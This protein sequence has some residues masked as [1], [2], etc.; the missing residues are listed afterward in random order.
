M[1]VIAAIT[2]ALC[3]YIGCF[4][5]IPCSDYKIVWSQQTQDIVYIRD[6]FFVL[7]W[8][9][10]D[11]IILSDGS[12]VNERDAYLIVQVAAKFDG[13]Y[14]GINKSWKFSAKYAKI[15]FDDISSFDINLEKIQ[16]EDYFFRAY[17]EIPKEP[18][19]GKSFNYTD[20]S[21]TV[22]KVFDEIAFDEI[23]ISPIN[24]NM[25]KWLNQVDLSG[26]DKL[27]VNIQLA[28]SAGLKYLKMESPDNKDPI[29]FQSNTFQVDFILS[30]NIINGN[31]TFKF[32]GEDCACLW[33]PIEKEY[34]KTGNQSD[35][36]T[37][38]PIKIDIESPFIQFNF[39]DDTLTEPCIHYMAFDSIS[40]IRDVSLIIDD[41][42]IYNNPDVKNTSLDTIFDKFDFKN[43]GNG[44]H[45]FNLQAYDNAG[46][47][48]S[49]TLSI[50][51]QGWPKELINMFVKD[52]IPS[53]P[54]TDLFNR[55]ETPEL[56]AQNGFSNDSL[57]SIYI[58]WDSNG[59]YPDSLRIYDYFN[60]DSEKKERKV[61]YKGESRIPFKISN[62][63]GHHKIVA[64]FI[65]I[66]SVTG[67]VE[68]VKTDSAQLFYKPIPD[69]LSFEILAREK[70]P[71]GLKQIY[72]DSIKY[73]YSCKCF[74]ERHSNVKS[75]RAFIFDSYDGLINP[76]WVSPPSIDS[77][78]TETNEKHILTACFMDSAGNFTNIV[79]DSVNVRIQN[80]N[81]DIENCIIAYPNPFDTNIDE[82]CTI[83][84]R[85]AISQGDHIEIFDL[86]G[87]LVKDINVIEGQH[88]YWWNGINDKNQKVI[89]GVYL[90]RQRSLINKF[91]KLGVFSE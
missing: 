34:E 14:Y 15:E 84:L 61:K 37:L 63:Y 1:K 52:T 59:R 21:E 30:F 13:P 74:K 56:N 4:A 31:Y 50:Q 88:I 48:Q 47:S 8:E 32:S 86:W 20:L 28:D 62:S 39:D 12:T 41:T 60:C 71:F 25:D 78:R 76:I 19:D 58:Q 6:S 66:N 72:T 5:S 46:N 91:F 69:T 65:F 7:Q 26:S 51:Y 17:L 11:D 54:P 83:E 79:I 9:N 45:N 80:N 24:F 2:L 75:H 16:N 36:N 68:T 55:Y 67:E 40:G 23:N 70:L 33:D 87:K 10:Q 49:N 77:Y 73:K 81:E 89:N 35:V 27:L 85:C 57:I 38:G 82:A 64:T 53:E 44:I 22:R 18:T 90:I 3:F 29:F 43:I 42:L